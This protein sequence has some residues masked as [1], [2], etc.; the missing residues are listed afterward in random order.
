MRPLRCKMLLLGW[1]LLLLGLPACRISDVPLW[2]G[3]PAQ[4][5]AFAV[6]RHEG[7]AYYDGPE[8]ETQVRSRRQQLDLFLPQGAKDYPVVMGVVVLSSV[9]LLAGYLLR[10][11]AY[12]LADPRMSRS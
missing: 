6:V 4:D 1:T 7:I 12:G 3:P 9:L 8:A 5:G 2:T 10:D 11:I